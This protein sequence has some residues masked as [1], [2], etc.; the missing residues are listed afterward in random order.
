MRYKCTFPVT[1]SLLLTEHWPIQIDDIK[2][3]WEVNDG[4]V[5]AISGSAPMANVDRLPNISHS[6]SPGAVQDIYLADSIH[7]DRIE[8]TVRTIQGL[9]CIFSPIEIDFGSVKVT[10]IPESDE[11]RNNLKIFS[12]ERNVERANVN[13]PHALSYE[14]V[15]RSIAAAKFAAEFEIP[16][17]FFRRG[18][19]DL[20]SGKYIE[21]FYNLFFF[22]ETLFAPGF[23]N[24][25][26]VKEKFKGASAV[27]DA[28][29]KAKLQLLSA[30]ERE[31]PRL[32]QLLNMSDAELISHLVD[33]RGTLHH[34]AL[35]REGIWHPDKPEEFRGEVI[36]LQH[37]VHGI[38]MEKIIP[39]LYSSESDSI[40]FSQAKEAGMMLSLRVETVGVINGEVRHMQPV[41]YQI[42]GKSVSVKM[43][44]HIDLEVRRKY[45][46]GIFGGDIKEYKI[47][48]DDGVQ[49][50]AIYTRPI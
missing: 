20:H 3:E 21:A 14:L 26:K 36:I 34:H 41:R 5:T 9:L 1:T 40:L 7:H 22:L 37:V 8:K 50:Y 39:Q 31:E 10:W 27:T 33:L 38:I 16:L 15:A 43:I 19:N 4:I 25:T 42:P 47:M 48:S 28:L 44:N 24:P 35:R 13:E 23:S 17:N 11:D 18:T 2:I 46:G 29:K 12:Y 49:T 32:K 6:T 30:H 45:Q